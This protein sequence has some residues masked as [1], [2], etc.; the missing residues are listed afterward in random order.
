MNVLVTGGLGQLGRAIQ[1]RLEGEQVTA[2]DLPEFDICNGATVA[3]LFGSLHPEIVINCAAYTNVDGCVTDYPTAHR[4]NA[5]GPLVL[6]SACRKA[7]IPMV[8]VSTNEVFDGRCREGYE[9][10]MPLAPLNPYGASKAAGEF[11]VRSILPEHYIVRTAWLFAAGGRNF[12]HAILGRAREGGP[13]RV[14]TDE[15][16]N[17][18]F[19]GDLADAIT[20]LIKTGSYGTYHF[21]NAGACS[22]WEFA[23]EILRA[24]G[25]QSVENI[26][27]TGAEFTRASTPPPFGELHNR[28][29]SAQ[30][31]I[32]RPWQEALGEFL[33][34]EREGSP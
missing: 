20:A 22:R 15:I 34:R 6:A 31:I 18:T 33:A 24:A 32:L 3:D 25:L 21:V 1:E 7:G 27:I 13:L 29:G 19:V 14:V 9:E 17:P 12:V 11:N 4:V 5:V 8:Q 26:P 2:V 23:G 30:G 10:W 16:G 28:N